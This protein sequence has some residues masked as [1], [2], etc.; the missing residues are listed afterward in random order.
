MELLPTERLFVRPPMD[1]YTSDAFVYHDESGHT[2]S[3]FNYLRPGLIQRIKRS[4][5][6]VALELAEPFFGGNAIDLGC[7][8]GILLPSLARHFHTVVG[9]DEDPEQIRVAASLVPRLGE[10]VRLVCN[11]GLSPQETRERLG[12]ELFQIGFLLE[13]LEHVGVAADMY[14][15]RMAFLEEAFDLL[16]AGGVLIMSVPKM[17]GLTFLAKHALQAALG[18][19]HERCGL[20]AVLR[21]GLLGDTESLEGGWCGGHLGFNHVKLERWLRARF[22]VLEQVDTLT[23]MFYVLRRR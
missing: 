10:R 3:N 6:E 7:A 8:D 23:S 9:I 14:G 2:Y 18:L 16:D 15:S 21:A 5:F 11:R 1:V 12:A 13:T 4:R 19:P 20:G 22:A 17:V